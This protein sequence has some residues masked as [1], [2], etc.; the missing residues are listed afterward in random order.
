MDPSGRK[1]LPPGRFLLGMSSAGKW[2]MP[3]WTGAAELEVPN[4]TK[5][6]RKPHLSLLSPC[7]ALALPPCLPCFGV[8]QGEK[9]N[10]TF[11]GMENPT[12]LPLNYHNSEIK[13]LSGKEMGT[14]I[15]NLFKS[16][17]ADVVLS[18]VFGIRMI[19]GKWFLCQGLCWELKAKAGIFNS[20][21]F[22]LQPL[23]PG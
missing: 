7:S 9:K 1:M 2:G 12:P 19:L 3:C 4:V 18:G 13:G 6:T 10:G 15:N 22:P 8:C 17:L 14:G 23:W 5:A 11:L 21:Y 16:N 20:L